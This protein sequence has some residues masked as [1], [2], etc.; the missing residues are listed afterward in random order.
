M[1]L[2]TNNINSENDYI[3]NLY[4]NNFIF[5]ISGANVNG[6]SNTISL[7]YPTTFNGNVS[8]QEKI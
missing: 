1:F 6:I 8:I 7:N 2:T 5:D 3:N 4:A